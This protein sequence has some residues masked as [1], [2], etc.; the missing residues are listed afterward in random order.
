M[1][2]LFIFLA[3]LI[4]LALIVFSKIRIEISNLKFTSKKINCRHF[5]DNYAFQLKI[6]IL[7]E[8]PILKF[9]I[10]KE[11]LEKIKLNERI[12][13]LQSKL[14]KFEENLTLDSIK[15]LKYLDFQIKNFDLKVEIGTESTILTSILI[16]AISAVVS[17]FLA[18]KKV[19]QKNQFFIVNPVYNNGNLVN[20]GLQGIFEIKVI[21]IIKVIYITNKKRRV[22]KNERT[23]N[24]GAYGYSYE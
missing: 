19:P 7:N 16:P 18:S 10:T 20:I 6:L 15:D 2:F 3:F 8:I 22:E 12:K 11:K 24:R 17:I 5:N 4:L 1:V 9:N 14:G 13:N 23:S 21:H